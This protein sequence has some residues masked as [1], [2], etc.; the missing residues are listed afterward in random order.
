M[1]KMFILMACCAIC[2]SMLSC[3]DENNEDPKVPTEQPGDNSQYGNKT[4]ADG[5]IKGLPN[6]LSN[7]WGQGETD[8]W[9]GTTDISWY[10]GEKEVYHIN[11]A[12]QLAGLAELV[13]GGTSFKKKTVKLTVNVILNKEIK[14]DA[15]R[16]IINAEDLRQW[17]PISGE[18]GNFA[19]KFDGG[20]HI[21]SGLYINTDE[22]ASL[23]GRVSSAQGRCDIIIQNIGIVASYIRG[24]NGSFAI[25]KGDSNVGGYSVDIDNCFNCGTVIGKGGHNACGIGDVYNIRHC[26]NRGTII[27]E[28]NGV[29]ASGIGNAHNVSHSYNCGSIISDGTAYGI[30]MVYGEKGSSNKADFCYNLGDLTASIIY[31]TATRFADKVIFETCATL[32]QE[33]N[34][35]NYRVG[36]L[37]FHD[38]AGELYYHDPH[39]ILS[40]TKPQKYSNLLECLNYNQPNDLPIWKIDTKVNDGYPIFVE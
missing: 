16:N 27:A 38:N 5:K 26:F 25:A 6:E 23:F 33:K 30:G 17:T 28:G 1:K 14:L 13:N 37:L 19:G 24:G 35:K 8:E 18:G 15:E 10:D 21:V 3:S 11:S 40:Q 39:K 32:Y 36:E 34:K 29:N 31:T 22:L 20:Y 2:W 9:D 4:T 12:E 7:K